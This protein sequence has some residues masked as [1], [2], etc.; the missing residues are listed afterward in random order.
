[1]LTPVLCYRF[2]PVVFANRESSSNREPVR[3]R[4]DNDRK[5]LN[6]SAA[7]Q[8]PVVTFDSDFVIDTRPTIDGVERCGRDQE[9][10]LRKPRT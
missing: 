8:F 1:M 5:A 2:L 10:R 9:R 3:E 4:R 6:P 7:R